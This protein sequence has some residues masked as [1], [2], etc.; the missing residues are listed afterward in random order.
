MDNSYIAKCY[1]DIFNDSIKKGAYKCA[2]LIYPFVSKNI[3]KNLS[4]KDTMLI[5]IDKLTDKDTSAEEILESYNQTMLFLLNIGYKS[6]FVQTYNN[7]L[8]IVFRRLDNPSNEI[9]KNNPLI[10]E[11]I[12]RLVC[13]CPSENIANLV[14]SCFDTGSL[15]GLKILDNLELVTH[16]TILNNIDCVWFNIF[17]LHEAF[18]I[19]NKYIHVENDY[20]NKI[21]KSY[22]NRYHYGGEI[23]DPNVYFKILSELTNKNNWTVILDNETLAILEKEPEIIK[24]VLN[25][26]SDVNIIGTHITSNINTYIML[27]GIPNVVYN[28]GYEESTD[29]LVVP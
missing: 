20:G 17:D 12:K 4:L 14:W 18:E 11:L 26:V 10:H 24:F 9:Y 25:I 13:L 1:D 29:K 2:E 15:Y 27:Y 6:H 16:D 19:I 3:M 21:I 5:F 23:H 7:P 22:I 8:S 28:S